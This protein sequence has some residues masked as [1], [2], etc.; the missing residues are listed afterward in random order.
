MPSSRGTVVR[1]YST[2]SSTLH[3]FL[4]VETFI[5]HEVHK[6][7][8]DVRR[9]QRRLDHLA[10]FRPQAAGRCVYFADFASEVRERV[11]TK[12]LNVAGVEWESGCGACTQLLYSELPCFSG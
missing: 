8:W 2:M 5:A 1:H 4:V 12:A 10:K 11:R 7:P 6:E 9:F 3:C